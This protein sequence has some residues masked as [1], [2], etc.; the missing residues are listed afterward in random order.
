MGY[1]FRYK[2]SICI[3]MTG[4]CVLVFLKPIVGQI[5]STSVVIAV[6]GIIEVWV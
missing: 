5:G 1:R 2:V 4:M 6:I 3:Q